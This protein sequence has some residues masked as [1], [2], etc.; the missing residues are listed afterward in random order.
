[1]AI[2]TDLRYEAMRAAGEPE[3]AAHDLYF[4]FVSDGAHGKNFTRRRR[5]Q[6]IADDGDDA[7]P[8]G[9]RRRR[10][11]DGKRRDRRHRSARRRRAALRRRDNRLPIERRDGFGCVAGGESER[12]E[13]ASSLG[14]GICDDGDG[15][16]S[17]ALRGIRLYRKA[18][19]PRRIAVARDACGGESGRI[20]RIA[21]A[22]NRRK[23]NA[24][25]SELHRAVGA[26]ARR[27]GIGAA[28]CADKG[29]YLDR[30]RIGDGQRSHRPRHSPIERSERSFRGGKL[31]R[32]P[33]IARRKRV[34][35]LCERCIYGR[36][37]RQSGIF[38][39]GIAWDA[40]FGRNRRARREHASQ[41]AA[42][43]PRKKGAARRIGDRRRR[44]GAD[45]C[46]D[47]PR[48][49]RRSGCASV[50]RRFV[51]PDQRHTNLFAGFARQK[52]RHP[53]AYPAFYFKI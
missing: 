52:R 10:A 9:A 30:R 40:F 20:A 6:S 11:R 24:G 8:C 33:R 46:G 41:A 47:K 1:M 28:R 18:V 37:S 4:A 53:A 44:F 26:D 51:L 27:L 2:F 39:G 36:Q 48:F 17:D 13:C 22:E 7:S 49:A 19:S 5:D 31:R 21:V 16:R 3:C 29:Q 34:F 43:H 23:R 25:A 42:R 38:S 12:F 50:S 45:H 15:G 35:R 14:D 32:D